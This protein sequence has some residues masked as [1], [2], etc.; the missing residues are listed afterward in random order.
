MLKLNTFLY[1]LIAL[2]LLLI[3]CK[4]TSVNKYAKDSLELKQVSTTEGNML[5]WTRLNT[6]DFIRYEVYVHATSNI[7]ITKLK[8]V[9]SITDEDQT[10]INISDVIP[11]SLGLAGT[12]YYKLV[13]VL[14]NR[15]VGS[16]VLSAAS[17]IIYINSDVSFKGACTPLNKVFVI[18]NNTSKIS[19]I[20][21][22]TLAIKAVD[23]ANF[24]FNTEINYG[25][26]EN[27]AY[28]LISNT[29][30][31]VKTYNIETALVDKTFNDSTSFEIFSV[32]LINGYIIVNKHHT[33]GIYVTEVHSA[34]DYSLIS[35]FNLIN[36]VCYY[37]GVN[38]DNTKFLCQTN[39][40]SEY[41]SL[42]SSGIPTKI[43]GAFI[44]NGNGANSIINGDGSRIIS[45][46]QGVVYDGSLAYL[47][48]L[49][50]NFSFAQSFNF[51]QAN[52]KLA[53]VVNSSLEIYNPTTLEQMSARPIFTN[54][55]L[56]FFNPNV[57]YFNNQMYLCGTLSNNIQ[58]KFVILKK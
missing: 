38:Q 52:T 3:G 17:N 14:A 27:G 16:N 7:D 34:A 25:R 19:T 33:N 18:N 48:T 21:I 5:E 47:K 49:L 23:Q 30:N 56:N 31:T 35:T 22:T 50:L 42:S 9:V 39:G 53:V 40:T 58:S 43:G 13:G 2:A 1:L 11:D 41:F 26:N 29:V 6:S 8:P 32:A 15:K 55:N 57:L 44:N 24:N 37:I 20:D 54:V 4:K 45:G 36:S 10:T 12:L 46:S 51:N 28:R